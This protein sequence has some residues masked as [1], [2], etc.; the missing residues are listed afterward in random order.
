MMEDKHMGL[1]LSHD[2]NV[3]SLVI[4]IIEEQTIYE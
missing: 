3:P 2:T 1:V 4:K